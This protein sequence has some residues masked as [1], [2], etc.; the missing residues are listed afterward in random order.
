[1]V[2]NTNFPWA[3]KKY[4][5]FEDKTSYISEAHLYITN[6]NA[7]VCWIDLFRGDNE[8]SLILWLAYVSTE[9]YWNLAESLITIRIDD[10]KNIKATPSLI[11]DFQ[12]PVGN[13]YGG[14]KWH[15]ITVENLIEICE[16]SIIEMKVVVGVREFIISKD[17]N[18]VGLQVKQ[19]LPIPNL[20]FFRGF[21]N[22]VYDSNAYI[23]YLNAL[24]TFPSTPPSQPSSSK[25]FIATAV[26]GDYDHPYVRDFRLL[27]DDVLL[28]SWIGRFFTKCY[29]KIS[30]IAANF[31]SKSI[32]LRYVLRLIFLNPIHYIIKFLL[33]INIRND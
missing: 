2:Y 17:Q 23:D 12:E 24:D 10:R 18:I 19:Y 13:K 3:K 14:F 33:R 21:Y 11:T 6:T 32:V 1:L 7:E 4:D 25:C 8:Q 9:G 30:P 22:N 27:R 15:E 5:K 29:Y 16:A 26:Y 20:A 28:R 31:I